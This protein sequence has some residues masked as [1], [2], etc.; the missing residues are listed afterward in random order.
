MTR[1]I[2]AICMGLLTSICAQAADKGA[3]S[4]APLTTVAER[5]GFKITG[6][7][8]EVERLCPA[9]QQAWPS[10]VRCFEFGRSPEGR[11]M[12]ALAVSADGTLDAEAARSKQRAVVLMQGGIHSGEIDGKDA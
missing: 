7:Y 9:F 6:R 10:Q 12:L 5:S 4:K 11:R 8:E 1:A 2:V 3:A